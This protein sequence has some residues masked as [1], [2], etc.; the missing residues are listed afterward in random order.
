LIGIFVLVLI[1]MA[2]QAQGPLTIYLPL[3][4]ALDE[5]TTGA[6]THEVLVGPGTVFTPPQLEVQAGDTVRWVWEEAFHTVNS[7]EGGV[8][9]GQFCSPDNQDCENN[10]TSPVGAVY[11]RT[12]DSAG[13][14]P[15]F[16]RVHPG[17]EGEVVVVP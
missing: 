13:T 16:C 14:F 15:Y 17:M 2:A 10:P 9:D 8:S 12:F 3:V 1:P 6:V 5:P 11:E 4:A 7:G